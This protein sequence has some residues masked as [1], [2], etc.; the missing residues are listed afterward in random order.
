MAYVRHIK[1]PDGSI[2][3]IQSGHE[4]QNSE[5]TAMT[6]RAVLKFMNA[7]LADDPTGNATVITPQGGYITYPTFDVTNAGHLTAEGGAGV[8]YEIDNSGHLIAEPA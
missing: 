5:G 3:D 7:I 2:Y 8:D 6:Q 4:V 1:T